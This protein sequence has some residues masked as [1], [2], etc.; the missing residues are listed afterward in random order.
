MLSSDF[1]EQIEN[2]ER[3][4]KCLSCS[5]KDNECT[6]FDEEKCEEEKI[7][8]N[9]QIKMIDMDRIKEKI[10]KESQSV[11][12]MYLNTETQSIHLVEFK[13]ADWE[14]AN[15]VDFQEIRVGV[16]SLDTN[17]KVNIEKMIKKICKHK[18]KEFKNSLKLKALESLLL[19]VPKILN[20]EKCKDYSKNLII[21]MRDPTIMLSNRV[22]TS[23]NIQKERLKHKT[24][25]ISI[26]NKQIKKYR[27]VIFKTANVCT[28]N[29]FEK[30]FLKLFK[31]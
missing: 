29:Q 31:T 9:S 2:Y 27:N 1:S 22:D 19:L 30:E 10:N 18:E 23:D 14:F 8:V 12:G 7:Q 3:P 5:K 17:A 28:P 11:D 15:N 4:I 16:S 13:D 25:H 24:D 6:N 26:M 21:V 20:K